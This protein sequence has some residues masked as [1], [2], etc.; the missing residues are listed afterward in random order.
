VNIE[1][2]EQN[3]VGRRTAMS[4]VAV[5]CLSGCMS[6][7]VPLAGGS[8]VTPIQSSSV[9]PA[10]LN[11]VGVHWAAIDVTVDRVTHRIPAGPAATVDFLTDGNALFDDTVNGTAA[12]WTADDLTHTIHIKGIATTAVGYIGRDPVTTAQIQAVRRLTSHEL[13]DQPGD[14]VGTSDI[15]VSISNGHLTLASDGAAIT[16][17]RDGRS[18]IVTTP[19]PTTPP[20]TTSQVQRSSSSVADAGAATIGK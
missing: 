12:K 7:P 18:P 14:F 8:T 4:L 11:Y 16:F 10:S 3:M 15:T 19:P 9:S 5:T 17:T 1:A 13:P 20:V 2:K 6:A